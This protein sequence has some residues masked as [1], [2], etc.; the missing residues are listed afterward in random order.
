MPAARI[1]STGF[2]GA[3]GFSAGV[4]KV[5]MSFGPTRTAVREAIT[6]SPAGDRESAR[7]SSA[8]K[9]API[10]PLLSIGTA[11]FVF[12]E[13]IQ[14]APL[15]PTSSD[16]TSFSTSPAPTLKAESSVKLGFAAPNSR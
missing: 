13:A 12:S 7:G 16:R 10:L 11:L 8:L 1:L 6:S 2:G 5:R 9:P 15:G 3:P 14:S 4:V